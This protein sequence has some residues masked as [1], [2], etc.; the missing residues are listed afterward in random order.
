M[1]A[2]DTAKG[3]LFEIFRYSWLFLPYD[4]SIDLGNFK[5]FAI[6][7]TIVKRTTRKKSLKSLR[8]TAINYDL[9]IIIEVD[10]N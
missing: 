10:N 5:G 8:T 3:H 2:M 7:L 1:L 9:R 6:Y 4:S